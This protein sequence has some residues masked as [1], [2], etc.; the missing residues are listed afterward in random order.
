M[1][2]R[3]GHSVRYGLG[4]E[5]ARSTGARSHDHAGADTRAIAHLDAAA[6][7]DRNPDGHNHANTG[8]N[9]YPGANRDARRDHGA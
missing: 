5:R 6:D 4:R 9:G 3:S 2:D 7:T 1:R 8:A